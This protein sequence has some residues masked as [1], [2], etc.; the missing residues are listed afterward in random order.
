MEWNGMEREREPEGE[1]GPSS[2][3]WMTVFL[4]YGLVSLCHIH[5]CQRFSKTG[6]ILHI[7]LAF[8]CV[9]WGGLGGRVY[10]RRVRDML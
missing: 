9:G 2:V 3:E 5:V 10:V 6:S 1:K 4:I 7:T 8:M